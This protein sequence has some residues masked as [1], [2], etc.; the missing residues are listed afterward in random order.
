M[1]YRWN[2]AGLLLAVLLLC[3]CGGGKKETSP[4]SYDVEGGSL[5][6][7]T[8]L[9]TL[10][11]A[12][13]ESIT[14]EE[15]AVTYRYSKLASG[16]ETAQA[17]TEALESEQECTIAA[18]ENTPG[19]PDFSQESG[20]VL[21]GKQLEDS[22]QI[23]LLT[24]QWEAESCSVTP[25]LAQADA[26]PEEEQESM[27]L[28]EAVDVLHR[29]DPSVLGLSGSMDEYLIYPQEG[30]VYLDGQPCLLLN[31]YS[32]ADHSF[33]NSYLLTISDRNIYQ[34][35]RESGQATMLG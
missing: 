6:S 31:V 24:I 15:G 33:E 13:F 30:T 28:K 20:Q 8:A 1:K 21:A 9:V 14:G 26:L 3:A 34:L 29:S 17:Y 27:T 12:E 11:D 23:L 16:G 5:P 2:A 4:E 32:A 10:E 18:D 7:L 35:D 25:S 19:A 22:E